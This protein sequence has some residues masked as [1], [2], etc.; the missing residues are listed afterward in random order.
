MKIHGF[1]KH[2]KRHPLYGGWS[3]MGQRCFNPKSKR[4]KWYGAG[5]ISICPGWSSFM[6]F[7]RDI[8]KSFKKG[9]VLD[10]KNND[11]NYTPQNCR[12]VAHL[13]QQTNKRNNRRFRFGGRCLTA[14]QWSDLA[15]ISETAIKAR[16][17]DY[18]W[19]VPKALT[20]PTLKTWSRHHK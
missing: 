3:M 19:S 14:R 8:G 4:F 17:E 9:L 10:R 12:W 11:G 16:I 20:T 1:A 13:T 15:G 7:N 6:D 18:G 2:A 5:G